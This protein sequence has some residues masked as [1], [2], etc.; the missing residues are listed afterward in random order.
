[1]LRFI[2]WNTDYEKDVE[3]DHYIPIICFYVRPV[4]VDSTFEYVVDTLI[5]MCFLCSFII[6]E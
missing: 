4:R 3:D 1:M 6:A 2:L 5:G